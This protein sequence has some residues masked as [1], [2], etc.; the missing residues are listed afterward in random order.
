MSYKMEARVR[1]CRGIKGKAKQVLLCMA[2]HAHDEDRKSIE[3]AGE[4]MDVPAGWLWTGQSLLA[5]ETGY[6]KRTVQRGL[7]ELIGRKIV[8]IERAGGTF[9]GVKVTN[10]YSLNIDE[11]EL[12]T[13]R[14]KW[15]PKVTKQTKEE[16]AEAA[17]NRITGWREKESERR[18]SLADIPALE[19]GDSADVKLPKST[20]AEPEASPAKPA[21]NPTGQS[22][23][24]SSKQK[25]K[26]VPYAEAPAVYQRVCEE[27]G[28]MD[29]LAVALGY[30]VVS[31]LGFPRNAQLS[32]ER[33][34]DLMNEQFPKLKFTAEPEVPLTA[35]V[36]GWE[37]EKEVAMKISPESD[38][39]ANRFWKD[40]MNSREGCVLPIWSALFFE[41]G[42]EEYQGLID[43]VIDGDW[44]EFIQTLKVDPVEWVHR[45]A[46]AINTSTFWES[47]F[48]TSEYV[49]STTNISGRYSSSDN[50]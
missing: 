47:D 29:D 44:K 17:R 42:T 18:A 21:A 13:I 45:N 49:T 36:P 8:T 23:V 28:T 31:K 46:V 37:A 9:D 14:D 43:A 35:A 32:V 48:F 19:P 4:I 38:V 1:Q 12:V 7:D 10:L 2:S 41:Y 34:A 16:K 33:W 15:E 3:I 30:A 50:V 26:S 22:T 27:G 25:S 11:A 20:D 24:K 39:L 5:T 40:V 6:S